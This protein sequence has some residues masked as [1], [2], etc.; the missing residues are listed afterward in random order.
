MPRYIVTTETAK[1]RIF[2]LLD[3]KYLPDNMIIAIASDSTFH[4]GVLQSR[5]HVEWAKETGGTLEDRPRYNKGNCFD[6]FPFPAATAKQVA[7]IS[8][9]AEELD[10]TRKLALSTVSSLTMTELYNLR[11]MVRTG[12]AMDFIMKDRA[13]QA[14]AGIINR[15]HEQLDQAV[16]QTASSSAARRITASSTAA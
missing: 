16:R 7:S 14:R 5:I 3:A 4:L 15:L 8:E 9:L 1:H 10:D 11:D 2:Q 12:S 13:R 6:P